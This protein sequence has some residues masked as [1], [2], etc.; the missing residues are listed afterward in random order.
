VCFVPL[1]PPPPPP[2][3]DCFALAAPCKP[4]SAP[5]ALRHGN[6]ESR[7]PRTVT[8]PRAIP[9]NDTVVSPAET[10]EQYL[11]QMK[12]QIAGARASAGENGFGTGSGDDGLANTSTGN[13]GQPATPEA[14][15]PEA[16]TGGSGGG[17]GNPPTAPPGA[18]EPP[19]EGG[20]TG[21][22]GAG[23]GG[24]GPAT[25]GQAGPPSSGGAT[26]VARFE[27]SSSGTI[28]KILVE[29]SAVYAPGESV[30]GLTA[31]NVPDDVT[32][33][34]RP[35]GYDAPAPAQ[36]D[37]VTGTRIYS[38]GELSADQS[39]ASPG[40]IYFEQPPEEMPTTPGQ[41]FLYVVK[42]IL[43]LIHFGGHDVLGH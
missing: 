2:P 43:E 14:S 29:P 9:P 24:N 19:A 6:Y 13:V 25:P 1:P 39:T 20:G 28:T 3:Q 10:E 17:A 35:Y 38:P 32:G 21:G 31:S 34:V 33:V 30:P 23:G 41:K 18:A 5:R 22:G 27:V 15:G 16:G 26:S 4:P 36:T 11:D 40:R 8:N 37:P 12:S 42:R 7:P